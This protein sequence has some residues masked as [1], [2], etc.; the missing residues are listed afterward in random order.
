MAFVQCGVAPLNR[1]EF[2]QVRVK[3]TI[4]RDKD[5]TVS[6]NIVDNLLG[7]IRLL[8]G[9]G[10]ISHVIF[11]LR[12]HHAASSRVQDGHPKWRPPGVK[13][14]DPL[15]DESRWRNNNG[16]AIQLFTEVKRS[17]K[18]YHLDCRAC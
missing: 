6:E 17:Q 13:M 5:V 12:V 18:G 8:R 9:P 14:L 7:R 10:R 2:V 1:S 11:Q 15:R 16:R 3:A 4:C